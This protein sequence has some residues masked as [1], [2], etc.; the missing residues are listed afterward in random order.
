MS[1]QQA[2]V[3]WIIWFAFLQSAL[4]IPYAIGGGVPEGDNVAEP[5][6]FWLWGACAGPILL[7]T[8]LRWLYIPKL[9]DQKKMLVALI[10]GLALSEQ[11]IFFALFL[12]GA[13]YPQNQIAVLMVAV[14]SIIQFAPSYG[15]PGYKLEE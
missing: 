14:V 7:A 8:A 12:I 11:P 13:D 15:T 10:V 6:A 1:K 4:I 9:K 5:M 3:L 2:F